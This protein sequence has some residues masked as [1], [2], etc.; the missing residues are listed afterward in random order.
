MSPTIAYFGGEPLGAPVLTALCHAGLSPTLVVTNPDR[1]AGRKLE[2]TPPPTKVVAEQ[3]GISVY[4][5]E[6]KFTADTPSPLTE[7]SFDLFVVVAYN[8]ILP[9]WLI[10]LPKHQ[11]INLHPSLLPKYR[12][13]SPIRSAIIN[14]DRDAVGVSVMLLDEQMDHGPILA[15]VPYQVPPSEWP[16]DGRM[17]DEALAGVGSALLTETIPAWIAGSII[18]REQ[19]H[20][21]A[22]YCGRLNRAVGELTIDPEH[23]PTG[24][25]AVSALARIRGLAGWPGTYFMDHGL[26]I[27]VHEASLDSTGRLSIATVTPEGK[28][29][30]PFSTY[31]ANRVGTSGA[32]AMK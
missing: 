12:G 27:K 20:D 25:E 13:A 30:Q 19:D 7:T 9:S 31:L 11:T 29:P 16:I 1:P 23:L 4:Q 15:Q 17:L 24:P 22:T 26:R 10:A 28:R 14:N 32:G 21:K 6:G 8:K 3:F 2:L 5:P 18:P